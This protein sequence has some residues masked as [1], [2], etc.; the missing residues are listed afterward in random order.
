MAEGVI[1]HCV[2]NITASVAR[3]ASYALANAILPYLHHVGSY[4]VVG[5]LQQEPALGRG[6]NL[7]EGKL[8]Q[9]HVAAA[10]GREVEIQ[11]P[12]GADL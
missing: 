5:A 9:P 3:T 11:F 1:H 7:Y 12:S 4:G 2:P 8:A 10:L 6:V